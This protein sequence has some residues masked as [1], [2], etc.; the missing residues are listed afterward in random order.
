[1]EDVKPRPSAAS[2][3]SI[4]DGIR[5]LAVALVMAHHFFAASMP[6]DTALD[7]TVFAVLHTGWCGVDMF[8]VLSGYLITGIL[9]RTKGSGHYFR[10]FYARRTVR[11]FPLYYATLF[12]FFVLLPMVDHPEVADY[13]KPSQPDQ[14]WF[15]AYL[16]NIRIAM[17]GAFYPELIP[18][19]TW[20]LAIEEQFYLVWPIVVLL[21]SRRTLMRICVLLIVGA[22]ALRVT[23]A[24]N[25]ASYVLSYVIT[26][27][28][29]D[30]LALGS[31]LALVSHGGQL[32]RFSPEVVSW[33]RRVLLV[34]VAV[35]VWLGIRDGMLDPI[36]SLT[37]TLGFSGIAFLYGAFL[38]LC[39][40]TPPGSMLARAVDNGFLRT[41]GKYSYALYLFHGP[42]GTGMRLLYHPRHQPL[43]LGSSLPRTLI[44]VL[45]A[46]VA[47]LA[48]AFLSWHLM[49]KHFLKLKRYFPSGN[50]P[51]T[52]VPSE[53]PGTRG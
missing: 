40:S 5:G 42:V 37:Y 9:F 25:G 18:N 23:L 22:L 28:R 31:F 14:L 8:F 43:W 11:I 48:A 35:V 17:R 24:L 19:V 2:H 21:C 15:W 36:Q 53:A 41:L 20:S 45:I 50:P 38:V 34:S 44:Y 6:A 49:E 46:S 7:R 13:I 39:I 1:M 26:P 29:I 52:A 16:T 51:G 12:V 3:I 47:S 10:S 32:G 30:C 27:A 4:L 33:A